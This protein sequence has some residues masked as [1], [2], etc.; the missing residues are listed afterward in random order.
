MQ[1]PQ[2]I[3]SA[4]WP[5]ASESWRAIRQEVTPQVSWRQHFSSPGQW[6]SW[7]QDSRQVFSNPVGRIIGHRPGFSYPLSKHVF[8][9]WKNIENG[10]FYLI[11]LKMFRLVLH[12][13]LLLFSKRKINERTTSIKSRCVLHTLSVYFLLFC[14]YSI[15]MSVKLILKCRRRDLKILLLHGFLH[16]GFSLTYCFSDIFGSFSVQSCIR[17]PKRHI[18]NHI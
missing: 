15:L 4:H 5:V 12:V 1:K 8:T 10:L 3:A 11:L 13:F 9:H 2:N 6:E 17:I 18:N 7:W 14:V 16:V